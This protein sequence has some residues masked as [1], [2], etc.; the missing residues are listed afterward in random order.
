MA[1]GR[2]AISPGEFPDRAGG[3]AVGEFF[4]K[5]KLRKRRGKSPSH[6]KVV[7]MHRLVGRL[8]HLYLW[9]F[10]RPRRLY[11]LLTV[12]ALGLATWFSGLLVPSMRMWRVGFLIM[13]PGLLY[14]VSAY[15]IFLPIVLIDDYQKRRA[16]NRENSR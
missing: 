14:M 1:V 11:A 8:L 13:A 5:V 10:R 16:E 12:T 7:F 15:I 9:P 3:K 6:A 2:G 4:E